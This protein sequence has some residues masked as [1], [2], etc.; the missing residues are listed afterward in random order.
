MKLSLESLI[1]AIV[2]ASLLVSIDAAAIEKR[3]SSGYN[4]F[5]C[6]PSTAHPRPLLLVHGTTLS[7]ASWN[8]YYP[9]FV[10]A[11]YCTYSLTYGKW[12]DIPLLGGLAPIENNAQEVGTFADKI[13]AATGASQVR[14]SQGGILGRYWATYLGGAGKIGRLIGIAPIHH[15]TTLDRVTVLAKTVGLLGAIGDVLDPVAPAL[16]QMVAGSEFMK[17]LNNNT[18]I[19]P[20]V[21]QANIA[22]V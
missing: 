13:L 9:Y 15:G 1:V 22:T 17:K 10:K 19:L 21:Y 6:K 18:D 11:G 12:K 5:D 8:T 16:M 14:H 4:D 3:A 7:A 20:G 2:T